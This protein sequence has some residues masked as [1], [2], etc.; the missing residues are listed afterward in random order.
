LSLR[1]NKSQAAAPP[2][3]A[4]AP[5]A[6]EYFPGGKIVSW[7]RRD[8]KARLLLAWQRPTGRPIAATWA[9]NGVG[10]GNNISCSF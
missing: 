9:C 10:G 8:E 2:A 6:K 3:T 4:A 5:I 1:L 7:G